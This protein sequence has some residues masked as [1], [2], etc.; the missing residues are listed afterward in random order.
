[1]TFLEAAVEVLRREGKPLHFKELTRLAIKYDLLSVVGRDPESMMQTR[2]Q[3]EVRRPSSD[4][5]RQ[6]PGVFGLRSYP[7]KGGRG[8]PARA[9]AGQG[10]S[11]K[12]AGNSGS[13][14][15]LPSSGDG[16]AKSAGR[17]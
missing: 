10:A 3:A 16:A 8:E 4:L 11:G 17:E 1:M 9:E 14:L 6:S 13:Q 2:L 12:S 7:P 15:E 5:V